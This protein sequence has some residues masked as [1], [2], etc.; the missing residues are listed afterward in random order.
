M[1]HP[2]FIR[3]FPTARCAVLC[4]A[5]LLLGCGGGEESSPPAAESE[6]K[7]EA[8]AKPA[9]PAPPP[10]PEAP[11]K[12]KRMTLEEQLAV[13]VEIP[14]YYPSDGLIYPNGHAIDAQM[15]KNGQASVSFST[16]DEVGDVTSWVKQAL[17]DK[18]WT[19]VMEQALDTGFIVMGMKDERKITILT[20][21]VDRA[22]KSVMVVAVTPEA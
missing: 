10:L 22:S 16:D 20:T 21:S 12:P 15:A 9:P 17:G 18:G 5:A 2:A 4:A 11:A 14:D 13:Q 3:T 6:P 7:A 8:A 1:R 19:L